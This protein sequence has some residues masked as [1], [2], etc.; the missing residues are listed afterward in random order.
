[1]VVNVIVHYC[2]TRVL[3][4]AKMQKETETEE[5]IDCLS[6]MAVQLGGA[7]PILKCSKFKLRLCGELHR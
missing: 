7:A 2:F 5:T 1:M 6:L 3:L 4:N